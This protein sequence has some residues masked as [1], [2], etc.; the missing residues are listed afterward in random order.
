MEV[1][2]L[3]FGDLTLDSWP[4]NT[5]ANQASTEPWTTFITAKNQ[6]DV[7]DAEAAKQSLHKILAI[8]DLESRHY[9]Q[10]WHFLRSLGEQPAAERAKRLYGVV[11]EVGLEEG[12][13]IVAAYA[14]HSARYYNYS[15]AGI[16]WE[17]PN[18]SMDEIIE[19]LLN[20]GQAVVDKIG[21]WEGVRPPPP[22]RGQARISMLCPGGLHFGQAPYE[23]LSRDPLGAPVLTAAFRLMQSLIA[24]TESS[25]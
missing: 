12:V 7:G 13:D 3:L 20:A 24:T 11:V 9:L 23:T 19:E 22:P 21:P 16:V 2:D 8:D 6:S 17:H 15:G 14:D 5:S 1:R 10:A 4:D 25:D 18:E